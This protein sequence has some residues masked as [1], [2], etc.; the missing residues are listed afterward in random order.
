MLT[1]SYKYHLHLFRQ[2]TQ[3]GIGKKALHSL[4]VITV[5]FVGT[6]SALMYWQYK[7]E[8][9]IRAEIQYLEVANGGFNAT[10][11]SVSEVLQTFQIAGAKTVIVDSLREASSSVI[12]TGY[13]ILLEDIDKTIAK[14]ENAQKVIKNKKLDI[15]KLEIPLK[16]E[17]VNQDLFSFY[18]EADKTLESSRSDQL[19]A[20]EMLIAIGQNL[21]IPTL[22]DETIWAE[23]DAEKIKKYYQGKKEEINK[24]FDS[25][26]KLAVPPKF[27]GYYDNQII[28][29]TTLA[30]LSDKIATKLS[31]AG[32]KNPENATQVEIAYQ[33]LNSAKKETEVLDKK[34]LEEKLKSFD[35]KRNY[36]IYAAVKIK[37]NSLEQRFADIYQN[38]LQVRALKTP[39]LIV[40]F[41]NK[42]KSILSSLQIPRII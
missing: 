11:Q 39:K 10:R 17:T 36:D 12:P 26:S 33:A 1:S 22:S 14:V 31:E 40:D 13:T 42:S 2:K 41:A 30:T 7:T 8:A 4:L 19:F 32:D 6:I 29:L 16:F 23:N 9:P 15:K 5:L 21:Y 35:L 37:E 38:Q 34:L 20:K 27:K 18:D 25:L 28:Y 24:S 3:K